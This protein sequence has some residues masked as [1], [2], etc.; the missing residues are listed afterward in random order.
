MQQMGGGVYRLC[1]EQPIVLADRVDNGN[2]ITLSAGTY[3]VCDAKG[4]VLFEAIQE[5]RR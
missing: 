1:S 4:E 5:E 2:T 3:R